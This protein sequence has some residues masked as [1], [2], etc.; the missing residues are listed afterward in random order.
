[1]QYVSKI[2]VEMIK[3][4]VNVA[5]YL[6]DFYK[7]KFKK[8]GKVFV[9]C[10][11]FHKE[12]TPSFIVWPNGTYKC[13]G[14]G[15]HGDIISFVEKKENLNFKEACKLVAQNVGIE[16][17]LEKPNPAHEE[18]KDKIKGYAKKYWL[19]LKK[20]DA[21][22]R[23][24]TDRGLTIETINKFGIGY[25]PENE[26][27]TRFD[28]G[29]ISGRISFPIFESK[30]EK[31][32][33]CI[34]MGYRT[35]KG[36]KPKYINDKNHDDPK[37]PL[38]G[39]FIKGNCLYGYNYARQHIKEMG[40]A[41]IVEGY[42]DVISMHQTG[43]ENTV[44]IMGTALTEYQIKLLSSITKNVCLFLD[45]DSAGINNM[46]R[47]LPMLLEAGFNV[48]L[49]ITD[50]GMDP[51]DICHT[52]NFDAT[53]V[54]TYI[55]SKIQY[56]VKFVLD[57]YLRKYEETIIFEKRRVLEQTAAIMNS[58]KNPIDKRIYDDLLNQ[59]LGL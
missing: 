20:N 14:C 13:F 49:I 50:N 35:L 39:V 59:R 25:V 58:I 48:K 42:M 17:T 19:N 47:V 16:Y 12:K 34:G 26:Y 43:L 23:Y 29:S 2:P 54:M 7:M 37:D 45:G 21:P 53:K 38:Y 24:L 57:N 5:E 22:M 32:A 4:K 9:D 15:E 10:C 52:Y 36:E 6:S 8:V 41:Y 56:A 51:A 30:D 18:Y 3:E 11:P 27:E 55:S 44:G 33:R 46:I 28:M 40:F 31:E 1:M